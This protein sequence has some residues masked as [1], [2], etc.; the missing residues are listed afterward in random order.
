MRTT[1]DLDDEVFRRLK[2]LA[3]DEKTSL[4]SVIE[5][6]LRAELARRDEHR[7]HAG[8]EEVVTFRGNGLRSGVNIDSSADLLDVME[9]RS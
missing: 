7:P 5:M 4:K 6:A 1:I 8:A 2:K 3:A 9:G